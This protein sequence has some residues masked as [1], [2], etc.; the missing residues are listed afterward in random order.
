MADTDIVPA[1]EV[2][3]T[4][5][6]L[7]AKSENKV[8][9]DCNA[10]NPAWCSITY[11][12]Y[13]CLDCS[14]LHRGMGVH[15][16][17]VRSSGLDKWKVRELRAME[18]GGNGPASEFF[19]MHGID[20]TSKV[21][22]KYHT[23]AAQL[24]R[25]KLQ[26]LVDGVKKPT[27]S[28]PPTTKT[29][30]K[31]DSKKLS[32]DSDEDDDF[33]KP[34][35]KPIEKQPPQPQSQPIKKPEPKIEIE[36]SP[37]SSSPSSNASDSPAP[38]INRRAAPTKKGG[39]GAKKVQASFFAEFDL[40]ED[41]KKKDEP[42]RTVE[43]E[44]T[45]RESL[46]KL[47]KFSIDDPSSSKSNSNTSNTNNTN[48]NNNNSNTYSFSHSAFAS[49][50]SKKET[51]RSN[52]ESDYARK[53]F[54]NAKSISSS[55][56]FGENDDPATKAEKEVRLAKFAGARSISSAAYYERD[57]TPTIADMT[58]S[59][60]ARKL[61]YT[62]RTDIGQLSTVLSEGGKK[63]ATAASTFLNDLQERYN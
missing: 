41:E 17:F 25:H 29:P 31:T 62:A 50:P 63:I 45:E 35:Q 40:E 14:A 3:A 61:A 39:L 49:G 18:L 38:T 2:Q 23:R 16:S 8:C 32:F 12:I 22:E 30:Q 6:R 33:G 5:K 46:S 37:L 7:K 36:E 57:E 26:G 24:Y 48:N 60:V 52:E 42:T 59:D 47:S 11:G 44:R 56:Y 19:R 53:N 58:A 21:E 27:T 13:I 51:S 1:E 54:S 10:K 4:F 20:T 43:Q 28:V 9:F 34:V 15:V 55:Q